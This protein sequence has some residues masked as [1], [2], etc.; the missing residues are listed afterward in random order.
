MKLI[1]AAIRRGYS[2]CASSKMSA[3]S[4][5]AWHW[6][7]FDRLDAIAKSAFYL[8]V[9]G[10]KKYICP[11]FFAQNK[12]CLTP[13]L[14][15]RLVRNE[16]DHRNRAT[17]SPSTSWPR[18]KCQSFRSAS[19]EK[20]NSLKRF[21]PSFCFCFKSWSDERLGSS[22]CTLPKSLC[23]NDE[24]CRFNCS[25]KSFFPIKR[26]QIPS[27]RK[28]GESNHVHL[29]SLHS[30]DFTSSWRWLQFM[31][32]PGKFWLFLTRFSAR[33]HWWVLGVMSYWLLWIAYKNCV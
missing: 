8:R 17:T 16:Q 31:V 9:L 15:S 14:K 27:F 29:E 26:G 10:I 3:V 28:V 1:T 20:C 11:R 25:V 7:S 22:L 32:A 18:W 21:S 12:G 5:S 33:I 30:C 4:N 19:S 13:A 23:W 24:V 6:I 2:N